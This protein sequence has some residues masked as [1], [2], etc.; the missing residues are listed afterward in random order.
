[1]YYMKRTNSTFGD[2][3]LNIISYIK[4]L[5]NRNNDERLDYNLDD[6]RTSRNNNRLNENTYDDREIV[7][8]EIKDTNTSNKNLNNNL[9]VETKKKTDDNYGGI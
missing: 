7:D 1:M 2:L 6:N 8:L 3:Y 5:F 4:G 9:L